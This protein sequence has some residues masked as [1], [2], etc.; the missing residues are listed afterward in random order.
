MSRRNELEGRLSTVGATVRIWE[1]LVE[2]G[3]WAFYR[4][5]LDSVRK[6]KAEE[7]VSTQ[8]MRLDEALPQE[9]AKGFAAGLL[10]AIKIPEIELEQKKAE[11]E[12][13]RV[14]LEREGDYES[15][16]RTTDERSRVDD[17]D[18][19]GE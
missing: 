3:P 2:G 11:L 8:V 1:E 16:N 13:L 5:L 12:T 19:H 7:V 17:S 10:F 6:T 14:S 4:K 15:E 9:F 18:F